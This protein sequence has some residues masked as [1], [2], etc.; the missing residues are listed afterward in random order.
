M[1]KTI[2]VL[3]LT[4]E[5]L[6]SEYI[7]N[8][9]FPLLRERQKR[10]KLPVFPVVCEPCNWRAHDWLR[11]TQA[12]NNAKPL[13][14]LNEPEQVHVL[15]KLATVIAEEL[16]RVTLAGLPKC[17]QS[18]PL[19]HIYL[20]KFPLTRGTGLR[21]DKLIGREQE[22]AFLDLAFAQPNSTI[23]TLVAWGGVGK[24][25]LVKHWLHRLQVERWFGARQVYAWSF[26]SQGTKED[27][28]ASEDTFLA[29]ALEWFG[30]QCEPTLSSWDKGRLL[31]DAVALV[32][33]LLILDGIEP[34]QYPPGP[35][36]GQ[37]RAP[38]VQNL[39]KRLAYK[40]LKV[41]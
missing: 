39:L 21:E 23:V 22:L 28:Q 27:R 6:K 13:S 1:K 34:L 4:K 16:S 30:V 18:P 36:G 8:T 29:Q 9:E 32:P 3:L 5:S 14:H 33:T 17:D 15:R 25:M 24:S 12:P 11:K 26:Y 40:T 37:L 41:G 31:A 20:N 38:G 7:L 2:A 10:D 19:D 35:L